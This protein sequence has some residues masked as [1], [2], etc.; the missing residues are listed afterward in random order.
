MKESLGVTNFGEKKVGDFFN[1]ERCMRLSDRLDGHIV[2]GH[3]DTIGKV[4]R[5]RNAR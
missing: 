1:V 3:I 2:S 5:E 4:T